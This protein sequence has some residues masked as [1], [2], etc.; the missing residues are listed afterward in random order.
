MLIGRSRSNDLCLDSPFVSRHHAALV[1]G[2]RGYYLSDLNSVNGVFLNGT[3][4]RQT[5]VGD[6]DVVTVGPF[7]LKLRTQDEV[8]SDSEEKAVTSVLVDTAV[9][10]TPEENPEPAH[11]KVIK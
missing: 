2:D 11:L 8:S 6:G 1:Q 3:Q 4:V 10:P 9:M 7:R 5:H